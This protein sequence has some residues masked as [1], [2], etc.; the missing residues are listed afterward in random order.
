MEGLIPMIN[1]HGWTNLLGVT[2][3]VLIALDKMGM[4]KRPKFMGGKGKNHNPGAIVECNFVK[5]EHLIPPED[6]KLI[7]DLVN[8]MEA[9]H[10]VLLKQDP[11]TGAYILLQHLQN[12]EANTGKLC[13]GVTALKKKAGIA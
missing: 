5:A 1:S 6:R 10:K 12:I 4:L 2:I 11:A 3:V 9:A 7:H 13:A 8:R